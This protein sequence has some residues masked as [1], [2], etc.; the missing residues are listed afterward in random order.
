MKRSYW[1]V[2]LTTI[3]VV[4]ILIFALVACTTDNSSAYDIAKKMGYQGNESDWV[5]TLNGK[6]AYELAVD[7]GYK[8]TLSEWLDSL[9][10]ERGLTSYEQAVEWGYNG[11]IQEWLASFDGKSAY[12]LAVEGGFNGTL[13]EW[14]ESLKGDKGESAYQLAVK[15]G[16]SGDESSWIK[17]LNGH[18]GY[19][20]YQ[21]AINNGYVGS[22]VEWLKSLHG[23]DGKSAYD[24]AVENGFDGTIAEWLDLKCPLGNPYNLEFATNESLRSTVFVHGAF[25]G[26]SIQSSGS[27]VIYSLDKKTGKAFILTC[28]HVLHNS[29]TKDIYKEI[30]IAPYGRNNDLIKAEYVGGSR[31]NDIAIICVTSDWFKEPVYQSVRLGDDKSTRMGMDIVAT[32]NTQGA[33]ISVT[34]GIVGALNRFTTLKDAFGIYTNV[35]THRIDAVI[36]SGNSGGGAFDYSGKMIGMTAFK[37][38]NT[39]SVS[40]IIPASLCK[41][42]ADQIINNYNNSNSTTVTKAYHGLKFDDSSSSAEIDENGNV[43]IKYKLIV[44]DVDSGG[45]CGPNIRIGNQITAITINDVKHTL[46]AVWQFDELMYTLSENDIVGLHYTSN[47]N[48]YFIRIPVT[49]ITT[50]K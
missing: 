38:S 47:G 43:Y 35:R 23:K 5:Q 16:Y 22:E 13:D 30:F 3:L 6:S 42:I 2:V 17:S 18:R 40:Y 41:T 19:S 28:Y 1:K 11:T 10:G 45:F 27:G 32:G 50:I 33:G 9:Q 26:G 39:A 48:N 25:T 37:D 7:N 31:F 12:D 36:D 8:G 49:K 20:A 14:N 15:Y 46:T 34:R 29:L 21:L 4:S 24:L 44:N